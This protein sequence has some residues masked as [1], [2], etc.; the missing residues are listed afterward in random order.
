MSGAAWGRRRRG[1]GMAEPTVL[2][3]TSALLA[4]ILK[5]PGADRV[6]PELDRAAISAVNLTE[7]IEVGV[8]RG[9]AIGRAARWAEELSLPVVRFD[10]AMAVEAARLLAV[11]RE[12][13]VSL[14]DCACLAT[15]RVLRLPVL[16]ADRV[17]A[18]LDLGV[19]VR[20][21]R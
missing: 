3:D 1:T 5:E 9:H 18:T 19:K 21:I 14:G 15:A 16:T 4:L 12:K 20:L 11:A 6:L 17:W 8:R 10:A 2:L 7:V 13:D